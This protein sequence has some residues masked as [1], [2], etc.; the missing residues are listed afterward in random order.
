MKELLIFVAAWLEFMAI[1]LNAGLDLVMDSSICI[2]GSGILAMS[3]SI[4]W[5]KD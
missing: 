5:V 4:N 2:T 3:I 1:P